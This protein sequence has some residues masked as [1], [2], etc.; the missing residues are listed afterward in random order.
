ME[1]KYLLGVDLGSGAIKLTL[2]SIQGDVVAT[3]YKEYKTYFPQVAW[4]EQEPEDWYNRFRDSFASIL[5]QTKIDPRKILALASDAATHTAV[6]MDEDFNVLRR[7]ILWTDQRSLKQS[8]YLAQNYNEEIFK[9]TYH[10]PDTM[11]TLPQNLWIRE[12]EPE[13][14][15]RT[16]RILFAKDYLRYRLTGEYVTDWIEALGSMFFDAGEKKWSKKLCDIMGFPVENLPKVV[17]PTEIVGRVTAQVAKETGL[18][19]GTLVVAGASDTSLEIL[20]AGA[21]R[22]GQSTVKLATAGRICVVTDIAY[23][24]PFLVNYYHVIPGL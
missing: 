5:K 8:E 20:A 14:W 15:H 10:Y 17:A 9:I 7:A 13:I 19:E 4:S 22:L 23:P 1:D 21:I 16:K 18:A 11:W 3:T 24:H 12:N 2:L 6:L